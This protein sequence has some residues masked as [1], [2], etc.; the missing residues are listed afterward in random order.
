M[1]TVTVQAMKG[2]TE[3]HKH[4]KDSSEGDKGRETPNKIG[5][6]G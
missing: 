4:L 6:E 5:K 1:A 2:H 3:L